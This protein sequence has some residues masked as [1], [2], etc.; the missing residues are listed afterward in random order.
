MKT[1]VLGFGDMGM[2]AVEAL[3]DSNQ[4]DILVVSRDPDVAAQRNPSLA[5]KCTLISHNVWEEG[6][7][8]PDLIISTIRN[9]SPSYHQGQ[10][11]A[12]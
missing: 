10:P 6:Q 4:R 1:A 12:D 2:K 7:Y 8:E 9:A 11:P 5:K 3:L